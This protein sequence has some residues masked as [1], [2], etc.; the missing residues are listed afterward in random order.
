MS[1]DTSRDALMWHSGGVWCGGVVTWRV[2]VVV[3]M[4]CGDVAN[5]HAS[6]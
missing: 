4:W 6:K 5:V 1:E 3:A 2:W